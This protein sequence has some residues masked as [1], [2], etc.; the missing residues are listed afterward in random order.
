MEGYHPKIPEEYINRSQFALYMSG[1][2]DE[3]GATL[4]SAI[5]AG[6][7]KFEV[8]GQPAVWY[9]QREYMGSTESIVC[10]AEADSYLEDSQ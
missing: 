9:I 6:M 10:I 8:R 2:T 3:L 4:G 1:P 7:T 5:T